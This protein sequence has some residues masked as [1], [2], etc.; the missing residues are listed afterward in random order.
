MYGN[1]DLLYNNIP[2][3]FI[4][5]SAMSDSQRQTWF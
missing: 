2:A 5:L 4:Q 3:N 1:K